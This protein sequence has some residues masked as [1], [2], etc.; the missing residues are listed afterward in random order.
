MPQVNQYRNHGTSGEFDCIWVAANA[1][2]YQACEKDFDC[3]NCILDKILRNI[4]SNENCPEGKNIVLNDTDFL[5]KIINRIENLQPD[6]KTIYLKNNLV[7]KHLFANIYYLGLNPLTVSILENIGTVKEYMKK[8]Y[9]NAEQT[10]IAVEGEWG[11]LTVK[12]PMS[13]LLLDKLNWTPEDIIN[14]QWLAL[15]VINQSEIIDSQISVEE[16]KLEKARL[17]KI[18]REYRDCCLKVN[19][20]A[21]VSSKKI[22]YLYQL[23]G[24]PEYLK[25]LG[26]ASAY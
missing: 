9:F 4:I 14:R 1:I 8:V 17:L 3:E 24:K 6:S 5:D 12:V 11:K 22:E 15:I 25:L 7:L 13:F 20:S 19:P 23:I 16:W 2:D 10:I 21:L 26:I 18:I